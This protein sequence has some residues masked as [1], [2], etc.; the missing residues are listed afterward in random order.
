MSEHTTETTD[1]EPLAGLRLA[2]SI[3]RYVALHCIPLLAL[4]TGVT[5]TSIIL[6]IS[7]YAIRMFFVTA[8]YHRYFSHRSFKTSRAMQA[9]FAF[10]AETSLQ[11]GVLWWAAHHRHHH[12]HSDTPEDVH[13]VRHG[14]LIHAHFGWLFTGRWNDELTDFSAVKDLA[15]YPE[16]RW[17]DRHWLVP[18]VLLMILC[19]AIDGWTGVVVGFFWSQIAVWHGTYT[20]NSLSHLIGSQRYETGDDSR[21]NLVLA[22]ITFGEGWHNNHHHYQASA[23]QGF[24]WW[25]IDITYMVLWAMSKVGLVWDL[26]KPPEHIVHDMPHPKVQL[27]QLRE[28]FA[29]LHADA[30]GRMEEAYAR[31]AAELGSMRDEVHPS[32]ATTDLFE[33]AQERMREAYERALA[34]Y[35][36]LSQ[37]LSERHAS[38]Q[39]HIDR[40]KAAMTE[41]AGALDADLTRLTESLNSEL[42]ETEGRMQEALA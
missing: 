37:Q 31:A 28:H 29:T 16:I 25:E 40:L 2:W 5:T 42:A 7:L 4:V 14:G 24:F 35:D 1:Y 36:D 15:K 6:C 34:S 26:R 19:Y 3:G 30:A 33:G 11:R 12:K 27:K 39:A 32:T 13:S 21:N 9:V 18:P 20:I 41:R 10:G 38:A 17:L 8:G 22:L 23:N